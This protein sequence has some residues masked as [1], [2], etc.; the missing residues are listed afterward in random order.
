MKKKKKKSSSKFN[1]GNGRSTK[2]SARGRLL[3]LSRYLFH[4]MHGTPL[5]FPSIHFRSIS[6]Y[7]STKRDFPL[8]EKS[9]ILWRAFVK[10]GF[11]IEVD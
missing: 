1:L 4:F 10:S 9:V 8:D 11:K 6:I 5:Y 7:V 3:S 2:P